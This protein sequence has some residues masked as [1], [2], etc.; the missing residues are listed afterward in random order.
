MLPLTSTS[1]R[2]PWGSPTAIP[3]AL[4]MDPD[5]RALAEAWFGAHPS[6]PAIVEPPEGATT[7]TDHIAADPE[8]VLGAD[9]VARFGP[10]LPYLLKLI[11]ADSPLALQVHPDAAHAAAGFAAE[12][13]AGIPRDAPDRAYPDPHHKPELL[14]ALTTLEALC[15]FRAPRRAAELLDGLDVPL[16]RTLRATL[17]ERPDAAGVVSAFRMLLDPATRPG[18]DAVREVA[19]ACAQRLWDGSPSARADRTVVILG[20]EYP[21]DPAGVASLLLNPVTLHRGEAMYIPVGTVHAY[22]SGMAVEVM[23]ASDNE[24]RGGLTTK[25][26]DVAGLLECLD[27]VAA[28][29]LRIAPELFWGATKV[30]YA[31]VDDFELSI[32]TVEDGGAHPLPGRGP[33]V[34][35]CLEGLVALTGSAGTLTLA[36]G[37]SAFASAA[38]GPLTIVGS[39]T[40]VQADVP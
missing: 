39:G 15:G 10:R 35:V 14:Y 20:E 3:R 17:L 13:A 9:V 25:P 24:L 11:A 7:L 34:L 33:R 18:S 1:R 29:P 32:T 21:G 23:A 30:F 22:L 36:R 26:T 16:A 37:Q 38:D 6:S 8:G 31:P 19:T 40:L 5:G 2:Y 28:P 27:E 12:E 4:G